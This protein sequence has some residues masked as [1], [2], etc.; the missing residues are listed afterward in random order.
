MTMKKLGVVFSFLMLV[1]VCQTAKA[2]Y[3]VNFVRN[4][5]WGTNNNSDMT[6]AE[7]QIF[8]DLSA[9]GSTQVL[10]EFHNNGP[11]TSVV[12]NI[13]FRD[14]GYIAFDSLRDRDNGYNQN[15]DFELGSSPSNPPQG[16]GGWNSF[17]ATDADNPKPTWGINNGN[18]TGDV[19]G[20]VFNLVNGQNLA[21]VET[22]LQN[23]DLEIAM[24]VIAFESG[25]SEWLIN[26]GT[27]I[28]APG[29]ILL[30][31]IGVALVGWLRRRRTL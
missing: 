13:Y 30:G 24:H 7:T 10:F 26:N 9:V 12:A 18:P 21:G 8:A 17:F 16:G 27:V 20:I 2:N 29:A 15:V 28:P 11:G 1:A 22:A 23:R 25:G 19:L 4:A 3:T 5:T 31:S 6:I 14:G